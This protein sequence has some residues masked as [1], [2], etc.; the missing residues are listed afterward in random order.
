MI[1]INVLLF[2]YRAKDVFVRQMRRSDPL[3]L[4]QVAERRKGFEKKA[5]K[6]FPK[7][8]LDIAKEPEINEE[9]NS[10]QVDDE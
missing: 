1:F 3:V 2:L 6:P 5:H 8:V 7:V 9:F 4:L 10:I